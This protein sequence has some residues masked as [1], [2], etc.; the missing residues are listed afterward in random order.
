MKTIFW[1]SHMHPK[2]LI[3][4]LLCIANIAC[5]AQMAPDQISYQ[6]VVRDNFGNELSDQAVTI[7]FAVRQGSIDGVIVFEEYHDLVQTNQYGL[8][9]AIIGNGIPTGVGLF[10]TMSLIPWQTDIYFL[11]VRAAIPGQGSTQILGVSQMLAVPYAFYSAKAGSVLFESDGDTQNEL[12][13]GF[14]LDGTILTIT[15]NNDDY[16]VDLSSLS[17]GSDGDPTNELITEVAL[18]ATNQLEITEGGLTHTID[19]DEA[20]HSA[21]QENASGVFND[22]DKIGIGTSTPTSN[23]TVQGSMACGVKM[24]NGEYYNLASNPANEETLIFLCD[25]TSQDVTIGLIPASS[26]PGRIYKF[27]KMFTGVITSN[28]ISIVATVGE[29]IDG[30]PIFEMTN[31]YAEYAAIVSNGVNWYVIEHS[32]D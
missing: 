3:F 27:R 10:T 21:W 31:I 13:D 9:S 18:N 19:L 4:F 22:T 12:I 23:L 15:E 28:D 25:V 29:Y 30:L 24:L 8:F 14:A 26:C 17:G 32:K 20:I 7:E 11:E 5:L 1:N 6:A 16:S 2:V